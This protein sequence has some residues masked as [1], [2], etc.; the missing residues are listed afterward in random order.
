MYRLERHRRGFIFEPPA[1]RDLDKPL[2]DEIEQQRSLAVGCIGTHV[3]K[4]VGK[5]PEREVIIQEKVESPDL[6]VGHERAPIRSDRRS[7]NVR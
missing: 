3:G 2:A 4:G 6:I 5:V 7:C 1:E